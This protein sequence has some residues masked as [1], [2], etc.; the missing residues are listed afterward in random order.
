VTD[1][2]ILIIALDFCFIVHSESV[3]PALLIRVIYSLSI[4]QDYTKGV[5][6]VTVT[7]KKIEDH[8]FDKKYFAQ[9]LIISSF[10]TKSK[11]LSFLKRKMADNPNKDEP[12][13]PDNSDIIP[14]KNKLLLP[15]N[16][17]NTYNLSS[18]WWKYMSEK[19]IPIIEMSKEIYY[20]ELEVRLGKFGKSG[21]FRNG[22]KR[23]WFEF[24]LQ[25][26]DAGLVW[27]NQP[28]WVRTFEFVFKG[29]VRA[30]GVIEGK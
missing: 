2:G 16:I 21:D 24:H 1:Y 22:V 26:M 15:Q 20:P 19:M 4:Y 27:D 11:S 29:N 28:E 7:I 23:E 9:I 25:K 12:Y 5:D 3:N 8:T 14:N 10:Q 13:D 30:R 17:P 18:E 6:Y